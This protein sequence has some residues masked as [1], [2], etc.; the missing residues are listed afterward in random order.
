MAD[1]NINIKIKEASD[2]VY[3][4]YNSIVITQSGIDKLRAKDM[5]E[6]SKS[7]LLSA[8]RANLDKYNYEFTK[9]LNEL[10]LIYDSKNTFNPEAGFPTVGEKIIRIGETFDVEWNNTIVPTINIFFIKGGQKI[11]VVIMK[12]ESANKKSFVIDTSHFSE[13]YVPCK[14]R[15]ESTD[16]DT[17]FDET[18]VFKVLKS[19]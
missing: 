17:I 5:D 13:E 12:E 16:I 2:G 1:D 18:F 6:Y 4:L 3:N 8:Y 11:P 9:S 7:Q 19:N 10:A 15:I 14:I